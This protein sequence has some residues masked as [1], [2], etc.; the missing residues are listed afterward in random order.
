MANSYLATIAE[1]T[2]RSPFGEDYAE[3]LEQTRPGLLMKLAASVSAEIDVR[4]GK[5]YVRPIPNPPEIVKLWAADLLTPRAYEALG[6]RPTDEQQQSISDRA[7]FVYECLK[8]AADAVQGMFDLPLS[9]TDGSSGIVDPV[10]L[11]YSEASPF[12]AKHRQTEDAEMEVQR[13]GRF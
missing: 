2:D 13:Y 9:D 11:A 1:F 7:K 5:R 6:V 3:R 8:E 10:T 12:T 4:I